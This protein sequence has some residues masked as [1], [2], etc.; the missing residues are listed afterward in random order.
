MK[1]SLTDNPLADENADQFILVTNQHGKV[2]RK[3]QRVRKERTTSIHTETSPLSDRSSPNYEFTKIQIDETEGIVLST[4]RKIDLST[5][6]LSTAHSVLTCSTENLKAV[7]TDV[8]DNMVSTT[9]RYTHFSSM[10]SRRIERFGQRQFTLPFET[11]LFTLETTKNTKYM[12]SLERKFHRGEEI[13]VS[14]RTEYQNPS[15]E[16]LIRE[17]TANLTESD[18]NKTITEEEREIERASEKF[19]KEKYAG[20][21][22]GYNRDYEGNL[23]P[24]LSPAEIQEG[25]DAIEKEKIELM[26][27]ARGEFDR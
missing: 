9:N 16:K 24:T 7:D 20:D 17:L 26:R 13:H 10:S 18:S 23:V 21:I 19:Y 12:E 14:D 3:L 4:D 22:E 25:Y 1:R 11:T 6:R 5:M 27:K 15:I 2:I 8:R